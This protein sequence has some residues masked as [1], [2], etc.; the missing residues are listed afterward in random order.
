M[1]YLKALRFDINPL[2]PPLGQ[3]NKSLLF[4]AGDPLNTQDFLS[5]PSINISNTLFVF[6]NIYRNPFLSGKYSIS[7]SQPGL[8]L[9]LQVMTNK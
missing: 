9:L 1:P 8:T 5:F 4:T 3:T 2:K 6:D 7:R